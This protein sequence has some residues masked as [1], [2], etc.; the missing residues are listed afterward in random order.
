MSFNLYIHL[1]NLHL[2]HNI[3]YLHQQ[4]MFSCASVQSS[5]PLSQATPDLSSL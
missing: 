1:D 5:Q 2:S 3:K 4:K